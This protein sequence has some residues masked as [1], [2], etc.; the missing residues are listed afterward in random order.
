MCEV[1]EKTQQVP[2]ELLA[3][4]EIFE[5]ATL[6]EEAAYTP[7]QLEAYRAYWDSVSTEKTL[8]HGRKEEGR[9]EGR[10]EGLKEGRKEGQKQVAQ[11]L[12]QAGIPQKEIAC[13]TG[14]STEEIENL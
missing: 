4:P 2:A 14:L 3:V 9:A 11:A 8:L 7:A 5:A 12:K 10:K 1:D 6:A 13:Y